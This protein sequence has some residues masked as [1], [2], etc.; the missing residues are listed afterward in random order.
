MAANAIT[1]LID[2]IERIN[3]AALADFI[4]DHPDMVCP[5]SGE[6][7]QNPVNVDNGDSFDEKS[8]AQWLS[9]NNTNPMTGEILE[10]KKLTPNL[11]LRRIII[12]ELEKLLPKPA[13]NDNSQPSNSSSS[14]SSSQSSAVSSSALQPSPSKENE[15]ALAVLIQQAWEYC[16]KR[17]YNHEEALVCFQELATLNRPEGW[18]GLAQMYK[19]GWCVRENPEETNRLYD[20][21]TQ[22][23]N[24]GNAAAQ[25]CL[26]RIIYQ[27]DNS[28]VNHYRL[29][30]VA[31]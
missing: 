30:P 7:M 26:S 12:R 14:S 28:V 6:I 31:W 19:K 11:A 9:N 27:R 17:N 4:E 20:L 5:I 22:A 15:E 13:Q 2:Q 8:I 18:Y 23:A 25:Y 21:I 3:P 16:N 24:E 10:N 1:T 29:K